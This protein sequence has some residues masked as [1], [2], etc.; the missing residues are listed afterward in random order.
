MRIDR[1]FSSSS[2]IRALVTVSSFS[3]SPSSVS[4]SEGFAIVILTYLFLS[5]LFLKLLRAPPPSLRYWYPFLLR[6][7]NLITNAST[8]FFHWPDWTVCVWTFNMAFLTVLPTIPTRA[9]PR[10]L[11]QLSSCY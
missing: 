1:S 9:F 7:I 6:L 10:S 3:S 11:E 8:L 4:S 2:K 5:F